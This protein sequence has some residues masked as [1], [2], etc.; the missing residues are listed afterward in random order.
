MHESEKWKWSRSVVS[1]S[2]R[3]HGL[4]PTRLLHP[5]DFPGKSTGVGCHCL[6]HCTLVKAS[7]SPAESGE[8]PQKWALGLLNGLYGEQG[9]VF[10]PPILMHPVLKR[11]QAQPWYAYKLQS[12]SKLSPG[13]CRSHYLS[14]HSLSF[15][16]ASNLIF[17]GQPTYYHGKVQL[18]ISTRETMHQTVLASKTQSWTSMYLGNWGRLLFSSRFPS[19]HK[20]LL[21]QNRFQTLTLWLLQNCAR[22][23]WREFLGGLDPKTGR[24]KSPVIQLN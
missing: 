5:W 22:V 21:S 17:P 14:N 23:W 6:L 7:I 8:P 9:N 15:L 24:A 19:K 13:L 18:P 1:D 4:Q 11:I 2:S 16:L 20:M 12:E 3:P 10:L